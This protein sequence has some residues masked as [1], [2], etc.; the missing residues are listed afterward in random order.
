MTKNLIVD[1][2]G[3]INEPDN[4][5]TNPTPALKKKTGVVQTA[6]VFSEVAL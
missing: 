5:T 4:A 2:G 3:F 1:T 6:S